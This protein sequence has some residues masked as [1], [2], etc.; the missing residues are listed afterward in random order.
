M[1]EQPTLTEQS[2]KTIT[3]SL[4]D[5][6]RNYLGAMQRTFDVAAVVVQG[7]REVNERGYDDLAASSRFLPAQDQHRTFADAKPLAERWILKNLL[8][9]SFAALVPFME[10]A[11]T[12]CA[13]H[14]WKTA[15]SDQATLPPVFREQRADFI[16]KDTA[17]R[18][19]H[20]KEK[21]G[22]E[23]QLSEHIKGLEAVIG[24]LAGHDGIVPKDGAPLT[25]T[26]VSLDLVATPEKKVQPQLAE[27]KKE[28]SP[29]AEI[30]LEKVDYMNMLATISLFMNATMR[31]LQTKLG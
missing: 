13:L 17:G 2:P 19:A 20:L 25:F 18:L 29:G 26:L 21:H 3:I 1:S 9:D 10:D 27:S 22:I 7:A 28:F 15:G 23:P 14:E 24:C 5:M 11:R 6:A 30:K 8:A 4:K 31:Q 12:I 16:R